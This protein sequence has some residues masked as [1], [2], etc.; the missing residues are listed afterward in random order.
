MS[1]FWYTRPVLYLSLLVVS[2]YPL[3][4]EQLRLPE[5]ACKMPP[6]RRRLPRH[7]PGEEFLRGPIPLA[8]LGRAAALRGKTLA[9][10]RALWFK[11]GMNNRQQAQP[12]KVTEGVRELN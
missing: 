9:V 6:G 3:D 11:A 8:W 1:K 12:V 5:S 7:Q 2:M 4:P 10:A